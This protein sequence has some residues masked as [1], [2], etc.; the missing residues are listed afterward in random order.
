MTPRRASPFYWTSVGYDLVTHVLYGSDYWR[1]YGDVAARVPP[2]AQVVDVCC[3]TCQLYRAFLRRKG[4]RYL[5]LDANPRFLRAARRRGI[6]ARRFDLLAEPVPAADFVVL[7][8][9]LYHFFR[10]RHAVMDKLLAAAREAVII[11]EPVRNLAHHWVP[12]LA[13]IARVLSDPGIGEFG[14]RFDLGSFRELATRYG[15]T[16][17]VHRRNQRNAIA[18]FGRQ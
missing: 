8:S 14:D 17:F 13:G 9:S 12:A 5:G 18:V 6:A 3:G 2:G 1:L 10:T 7:C 15:A 11:T 4:C 16:K